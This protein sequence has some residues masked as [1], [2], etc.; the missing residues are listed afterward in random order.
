MRYKTLLRHLLVTAAE[1]QSER[2]FNIDS[3]DW[4]CQYENRFRILHKPKTD[5]IWSQSLKCYYT[6]PDEE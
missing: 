3:L 5:L 4:F 1:N 2:S 6:I